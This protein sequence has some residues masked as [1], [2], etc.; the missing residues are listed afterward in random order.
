M[1]RVD[2]WMSVQGWVRRFC[3]SLWTLAAIAVCLC[4][5]WCVHGWIRMCCIPT[6]GFHAIEMYKHMRS[7]WDEIDGLLTFQP[8]PSYS[9]IMLTDFQRIH[10]H[11]LTFIHREKEK[12]IDFCASKVCTLLLDSAKFL[13]ILR[14]FCFTC[15]SVTLHVISN[16]IPGWI[17]HL[18]H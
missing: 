11:T 10:T 14:S 9:T 15:S 17:G 5:V 6:Y 2:M 18:I 3:G 4:L 8:I 1:V 12:D 13:L 7:I 16:G